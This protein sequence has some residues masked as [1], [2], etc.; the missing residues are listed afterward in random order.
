MKYFGKPHAPVLELAEA[1]TRSLGSVKKPLVI[2][3]GLETDIKGANAMGWDA[4]FVLGGVHGVEIGD[5]SSAPAQARLRAL[6][7]ETGVEAKWSIS[8]LCW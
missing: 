8:E 5:L 2:G 3:D 4:L 1:R 6:F 7:E